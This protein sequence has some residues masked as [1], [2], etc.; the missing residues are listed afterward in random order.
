ML[1]VSESNLFKGAPTDLTQNDLCSARVGEEV[2][3]ESSQ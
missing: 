2:N 3:Y 1:Q